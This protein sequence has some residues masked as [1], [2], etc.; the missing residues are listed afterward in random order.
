VGTAKQEAPGA[1]LVVAFDRA[2]GRALRPLAALL[3]RRVLR[4]A[5][6]IE[7]NRTRPLGQLAA[8][9]FLLASMLYGLIVGGQIGQLGDAALV[10]VGFGIDDIEMDGNAETSDLA[11]LAGLEIQGSLVGY[12]AAA[13]QERVARLPW[14]AGVTVR[15]FYPSTLSVE[16]EER[17]PFAL[18]QH[19]GEV[20]V[21]DRGGTK[22]VPLEESRFGKLPFLVGAG[23]NEKAATFVEALRDVP[24]IARQMRAAVLVA[25]RRWDLHLEHG[26]QVKLPEKAVRQALLQLARLDK[27]RQLLA[28]DV[29]V[30]DL[31]IP[32]RLTVRLPEGRSLKDVGPDGARADAKK[33]RT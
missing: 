16:V 13:A 31:R 2:L 17:K 12:D 19:E 5:E 32:D 22:I 30:V 25:E 8:V 9:L 26:V 4:V 15:K 29:V 21:V 14:V 3:P 11:I 7:R 20:Y 23:A 27:E 33:A 10:F 24:D 6:K 28:R 1:R 18:W